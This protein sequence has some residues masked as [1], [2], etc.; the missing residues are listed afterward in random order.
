MLVGVDSV[1]HFVTVNEQSESNPNC[2][3]DPSIASFASGR[4]YQNNVFTC[5]ST[6]AGVK[7]SCGGR[8]KSPI[9][10]P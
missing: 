3:F 6:V 2:S 7:C 10:F 9:L 1:A 4:S 8:K 5:I